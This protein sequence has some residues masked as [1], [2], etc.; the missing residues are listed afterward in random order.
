LATDVGGGGGAITPYNMQDIVV[1]KKTV[2][3]L[4]EY[5]SRNK[6]V[7]AFFS[8]N[9]SF[10]PRADK[11]GLA[12]V[13]SGRIEGEVR[14]AF[15]GIDIETGEKLEVDFSEVHRFEV[16]KKDGNV[17]EL[18]IER[19]PV[20][21]PEELLSDEPSFADLYEKHRKFVNLRLTLKNSN[22]AI[23]SIVGRRPGK[24]QMPIVSLGDIEM[25][26]R[27]RLRDSLDNPKGIWWAIPSVSSDPAYPY[28]LTAAH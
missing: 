22:G 11:V 9:G 23:L 26:R 14:F 25:N 8:S 19:F 27:I 13:K 15:V 4:K 17:L 18:G 3:R 24:D 21:T 12:F 20:I 5:S 7:M 1:D 6:H 2:A 10:V 28:G 16:L